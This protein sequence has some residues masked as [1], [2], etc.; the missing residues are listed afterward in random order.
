[1]S[2]YDMVCANTGIPGC[3]E[4]VGRAAPVPAQRRAKQD[5]RQGVETA[6]RARQET[7]CGGG[8]ASASAA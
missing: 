5:A 4:E 7:L 6:E 2:S 1:M 3:E 8:G